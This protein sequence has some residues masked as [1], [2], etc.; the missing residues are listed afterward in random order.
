MKKYLL[1]LFAVV[2]AIGFS[3]FTKTENAKS[4]NLVSKYFLY[5]GGTQSVFTNYTLDGTGESLPDECSQSNILCWIKVDDVM[6]DTPNSSPDSDVD[7][8]DFQAVFNAL[9]ASS[10]NPND[11]VLDDLTEDHITIEKQESQP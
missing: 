7:I 11:G 2:L 9:Q 4:S 6:G 3:A 10:P 5:T 8:Y 1:G